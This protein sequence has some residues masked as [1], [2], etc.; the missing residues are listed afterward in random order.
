[1]AFSLPIVCMAIGA[2]VIAMPGMQTGVPHPR[3]HLAIVE[4][5]SE[6]VVIISLMGAGLKLDRRISWR[7]WIL[8]GRLLGIAMP[9][10]IIGLA[11]L[12]YGLLD[13]SLASELLLASVQAPTDPVWTPTSRSGRR[14]RA[15]MATRALP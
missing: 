7:R 10:T 5:F 13:L 1:M 9:L 3:D 11:L 12:G 8:T 15:R 4:R 6:M 2:G 14:T